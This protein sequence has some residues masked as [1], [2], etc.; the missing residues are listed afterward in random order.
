M[1]LPKPLQ[2]LRGVFSEPDGSPSYSRLTSGAITIF[3]C[4]WVTHV[5]LKTHAI[6]DLGGPTTFIA[7]GT[8]VQYGLNKVSTAITKFS[9]NSNP[10]PPNS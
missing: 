9:G 4:A 7:G 3:T 2:F 6:P 5:V 10:T 8:G 1:T